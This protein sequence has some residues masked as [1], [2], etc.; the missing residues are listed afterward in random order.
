MRIVAKKTLVS[1]WEKHPDSKTAL[2]DWHAKTKDAQWTCSAD[3]KNTFNT[4]DNPGNGRFIFNIK[5]N[6][7]RLICLVL[8]KNKTVYI[9]FLGNHKEYGKLSNNQLLNI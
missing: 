3:V 5:E 7:Y 4:V 1:F 2:E 6:T 8:F 9:R